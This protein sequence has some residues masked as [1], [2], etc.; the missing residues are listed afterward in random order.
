MK[1][2]SKVFI[3]QVFLLTFGC[4]TASVSQDVESKKKT[5]PFTKISEEKRTRLIERL[6]KFI[7]FN[8]TK[9]WD[10]A[11]D[12]ISKQ[13]KKEFWWADKFRVYV[14]E[15]KSRRVKIFTAHYIEKNDE[16]SLLRI[17]GCAT[18]TGMR[19]QTSLAAYWQD[20]DWY[21]GDF[22]AETQ[23]THCVYYKC[24]H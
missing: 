5:Y 1:K 6:Q 21:F 18:W 22:F 4:L 8:R 7:E 19:V 11:H 24:K 15:H 10:N 16:E 3:F 9:D 12:M 23:C 2:I 14:S 13:F 17:K 20:D